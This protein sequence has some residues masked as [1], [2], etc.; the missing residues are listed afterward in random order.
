[1]KEENTQWP[2]GRTTCKSCSFKNDE[3]CHYFDMEISEVGEYIE[4][5]NVAEDEKTNRA[6]YKKLAA[7][8][9]NILIWSDYDYCYVPHNDL[10]MLIENFILEQKK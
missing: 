5:N 7:S 10:R 9:E 8:I 1:M 2:D 6:T 4:K 3:Y